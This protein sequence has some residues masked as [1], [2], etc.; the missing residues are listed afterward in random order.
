MVRTSFLLCSSVYLRAPGSL[1]SKM[2]FV[3]LLGQML[4]SSSSNWV[5]DSGMSKK[6]TDVLNLPRF[7]HISGDNRRYYFDL[8]CG[9]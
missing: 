9:R 4:Q 3:S 2:S 6:A 5:C 8:T 7:P 1:Y